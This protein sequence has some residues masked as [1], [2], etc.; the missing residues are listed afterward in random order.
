VFLVP[1]LG[2]TLA[3]LTSEEKNRVS[4]RAAAARALLA[5]LARYEAP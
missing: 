1:R 3:Q 2:R 5:A 4:A